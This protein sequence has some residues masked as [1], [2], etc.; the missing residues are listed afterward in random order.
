MNYPIQTSKFLKCCS[1]LA[2]YTSFSSFSISSSTAFCL[3]LIIPTSAEGFSIFSLSSLDPDSVWHLNRDWNVLWRF[4]ETRFKTSSK[5][6]EVD[7]SI[8]SLCLSLNSLIYRQP[9]SIWPVVD[10]KKATQPAR[11]AIDTYFVFESR[12]SEG[13]W[14]LC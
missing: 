14:W 11:A 12:M 2:I 5:F 1:I 3:S 6:W 10:S 8:F 13:L 4:S 9:R 7:W